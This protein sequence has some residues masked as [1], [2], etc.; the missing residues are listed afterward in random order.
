V[1]W[2][3]GRA[4]LTCSSATPQPMRAAPRTRDGLA[5]STLIIAT[6][7]TLATRDAVRVRLGV[8]RRAV[9][10]VELDTSTPCRSCANTLNG[11]DAE[12]PA[13]DRRLLHWQLLRAACCATV[14]FA[15]VQRGKIR[16]RNCCYIL[17]MTMYQREGLHAGKSEQNP[18]N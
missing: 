13:H 3:N 5:K 1:S 17:H 15:C 6:T 7:A 8:C 2:W 14:I 4:S 10:L 11:A 16:G 9:G 12:R 18:C